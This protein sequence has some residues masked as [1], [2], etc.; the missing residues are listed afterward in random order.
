MYARCVDERFPFRTVLAASSEAWVRTLAQRA[1]RFNLELV[2]Q[3]APDNFNGFFYNVMLGFCNRTSN[4][5][6]NLRRDVL[7]VDHKVAGSS[8]STKVGHELIVSGVP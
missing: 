1:E 8:S 3:F 6:P 2:I 7:P 5:K 4:S